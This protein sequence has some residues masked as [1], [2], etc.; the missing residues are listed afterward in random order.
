MAGDPPGQ[1]TR[2]ARS[3][4][5]GAPAAVEHKPQA[6]D[7]SSE[8]TAQGNAPP[9]PPAPTAGSQEG[10]G[11]ATAAP[12][13]A[14]QIVTGANPPAS[15]ARLDVVRSRGKLVCGVNEKL[16]GFSYQAGTGDWAGI[17]VDFCRAVAV[18][19][20]GDAGKV[21][22]VPLNASSRFDALKAEKIDLLSRNTTWTMSREVDL[23]LEFGGV[24]YFDGQGFLT[25]EERGLVSAQQLGGAK[26]CVQSATTTETNMAYYFKAHGVSVETKS[27]PSRDEM[28]KAYLAGECDAYSADRSSLFSDRAGFEEPTK[29]AVL[30]EVI[31]KE[32]LGPAVLQGDREWAE[33]VRWV[34]AGL[35]NAEEVGL[36]RDVASSG[37]EL[38]GDANR[39]LDGAGTTGTKLRLDRNW[40]RN[41]VAAVGNYG[42]LY[43]TNIGKGGALG[44]ERGINALWKKGGILFAPPMW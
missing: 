14:N 8:T 35:I 27:F 5:R 32:P 20:L 7:R 43:D 28:I 44:M 12:A 13:A 24:L 25:S 42:E 10:S 3:R 17:D 2:V 4:C 23:G 9:P 15:Q 38:G 33:I 30:P 21:E 29:H 39:L 40:L 19:V 22:F 34:L 36:M 11:E 26:V 41:V 18:A 16:L 6:R 37:K 31:S 1:F